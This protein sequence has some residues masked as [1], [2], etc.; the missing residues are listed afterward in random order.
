MTYQD[1]DVEQ[2]IS[3]ASVAIEALEIDPGTFFDAPRLANQIL[4]DAKNK[5]LNALENIS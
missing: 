5:L 3:A 4:G 1:S 2:L